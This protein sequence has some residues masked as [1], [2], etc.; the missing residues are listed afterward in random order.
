MKMQKLEKIIEVAMAAGA[1]QADIVVDSGESINVKVES[2]EVSS[3]EVSGTQVIGLRVIKDGKIGSSY[4]ETADDETIKTLVHQALDNAHY[5][6]VEE[7][8]LIEVKRSEVLDG[9]RDF[10]Y[11]DSRA[12]AKDLIEMAIKLESELMKKDSNLKT[13]PYNGVGE[14]ID[15]RLYLNHL[16]TKCVEKSKAYSC[17]TAALLDTGD[18]QSMHVHQSLT[19]KFEDLD[20]TIC[21]EQ[22][23]LH[24]KGLIDGSALKTGHYDIVF[25]TDK[26]A[27]FFSVFSS[28]FSAKAAVND[29][30][31]WKEK[32]NEVVAS[33]DLK[34]IDNPMLENGFA[35]SLFDGEGNLMSETTLIENGVLKNFYQ[36]SATAKKLGLVNTF[37]AT[38]GP[39]S[40]L[41]VG[42]TN[43]IIS[44]VAA[45]DANFEE[46]TYFEIV[47]D[48]GM[49]SGADHI[50]GDFSFA[51][52]GYLVV[53]GQRVQA[54]KG[55][56]V[57][58]NFF[59]AL[60]NISHIGHALESNTSATF[61]SP[62]IRFDALSVAGE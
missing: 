41:G 11:D 5:S 42:G 48:Q 38:R 57:S 33:K 31:P 20:P 37:N 29:M 15:E 17:Y 44:P 28:L 51:A 46:G 35:Y 32:L 18:K 9:T 45:N 60:K 6:K 1:D 24:A 36:N 7:L 19:R 62:K 27:Q 58:G 59:N 3:Y 12:D 23:F 47:S 40:S 22:A 30:N 25:S 56:T 13:P 4:C 21:I 55:V 49:H 14:Y 54:V 34:I 39:K 61:F 2:G 16:G 8:E 10:K 26:L 43:K 52:S 53:N 50:S